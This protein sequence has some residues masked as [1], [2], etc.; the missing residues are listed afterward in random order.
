MCG[1]SD[2]Y[3]QIPN[4]STSNNYETFGA[5]SSDDVWICLVCGF[6]GCGE[7]RLGHIREHY[8][9]TLHVYAVNTH[10]RRVWDF[11]GIYI[12][13]KHGVFTV[14]NTYCVVNEIG[15]GYVHRL[16]ACR[17]D[18]VEVMPNSTELQGGNHNIY[19]YTHV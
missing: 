6:S 5:G 4:H 8:E 2:T 15:Q 11:A 3:A 18:M 14:L 12:H 1:S 10:S 7:M 16:I 9:Q 17:P 19:I 13:I